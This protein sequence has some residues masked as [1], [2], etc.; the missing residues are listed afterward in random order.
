[1]MQGA[2]L[3]TDFAAL[4]DSYRAGAPDEV[5]AFICAAVYDFSHTS[6]MWRETGNNFKETFRVNMRLHGLSAAECARMQLVQLHKLA[7]VEHSMSTIAILCAL[8]ELTIEAK[9]EKAK[10][11]TGKGA[12]T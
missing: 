6:K 1:M 12:S 4:L 10:A 9:A 8:H 3:K 7:H 2:F 11:A 5:L